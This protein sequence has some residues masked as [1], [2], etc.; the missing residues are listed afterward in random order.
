MFRFS[1][2]RPF[3]G[4]IMTSALALCGCARAQDAPAQN[5]AA[6]SNTIEVDFSQSPP[7]ERGLTFDRQTVQAGTLAIK[8]QDY[9]AWVARKNLEPKM[10]WT[11]SFRFKVTDP[12][13]QG[14]K[15]PVVDLEI[16]YFQEADN[17]IAVRADTARGSVKLG[18]GKGNSKNW[19]T[20][21]LRL[22]D[23]YFGARDYPAQKL[24]TAGYDLR[25]DGANSD[26]WIKSV[27]IT[28]YPTGEGADWSRLL[29]VENARAQT[30]GGIL[31]FTRG[32]KNTL[33]F[34]VRNGANVARPLRYA[35]QIS[36][37]DGKTRLQKTGNTEIAPQSTQ[38][39]DVDFDTRN[40]PLGPYNGTISFYL[41][42]KT[43]EP[44]LQ[45][46]FGLGVVSDTV[47]PKARAGEFLFG[48]DAANSE[49]METHD[50]TA[51]ACY[52][53][54]GVDILR[55][56]YSKSSQ[57]DLAGTGADLQLLAREG[58]QTAIMARP[59][60]A[61]DDA[62]KNAAEL[63]QVTANLEAMA[64]L[65]AGD[66]PGKLHFWELGNEP[67]LPFFYAGTMEQYAAAMGAMYDAIKRG[68]GE[69][70]TMVM[71]GG[72]SFAGQTGDARSREFVQIVDP[73][74]LDI[75]AYHGHGPGIG[76][77]R[78]ALERVRQVA[79][80]HN[81][82]D[83]GFIETE[84]GYAAKNRAGLEEQA[85]TAVEK[86]TYAQSQGLPTFF[87]FRLF[88]EGKG[89]YGLTDNRVEPRPSVLA[90]RNLVERLRHHVF[91]QALPFA[92]EA[93]APGVS[94]FLF[95]ERDANGRATGRK[96]L[97]AF[98]E[99]A[100]SYDLSLRL[101]EAKTRIGEAQTFDL[102]GNAA[103]AKILPGNVAQLSVGA[104]PIYL[105]WSSTNAASSVQIAPSFLSVQSQEPLL[106]GQ[107]TPLTLLA[108]NPTNAPLQAELTI[109]ATSRLPIQ[110]TPAKRAINLAPGASQAIEL[111]AILGQTTAPLALPRWWKVF[112]N[113]DIGQLTGANYAAIPDAL[114]GAKSGQWVWAPDNRIN[115]GDLAGTFGEK[116]PAVAY[117]AID[118]AKAVTLPVAASAD[119]WM[120]WYLNGHK[121]YDTLE[122]GDK[123]SLADQP[124]DLPLRQGRNVLAVLVLSGSGGW[125]IEW[126]GPRER[127]LALTNSAPD[128]LTAT[129]TA[130]GV[131]L[132]QQEVPLELAAPIAPIEKA[133]DSYAGWQPLEPLAVLG[134]E[135]VTNFWVQEPDQ[136]RW[137]GG[138]K[139]LSAQV[140]LRDDGANLQL[141][142]AARDDKL[143]EAQSVADLSKS[144][145][146]RLVLSGPNGTLAEVRAGL[147]AGRAQITG[148]TAGIAAQVTRDENAP[149][150]AAT[151]YRLTIPKA[152]AGQTPFRLSLTLGDNDS[153]FLKQE[154]RLGEADKPNQGLRL[155]AP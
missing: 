27:K 3:L 35:V 89:A 81:K 25:I 131:T 107:T 147:V 43:T 26:L 95:E 68:A 143:V 116:R 102:Y 48:L 136:S 7:L 9:R 8:G 132:A 28:G 148:K 79:V 61:G 82:A 127:G 139:D 1:P 105:S 109:A 94:A 30:P 112:L 40:W 73:K 10:N 113:P 29:Q 138:D 76:A 74:K 71:N 23:A 58:L 114:P 83:L 66:G 124:F 51:L 15:M 4:V 47:L 142:V 31:A 96:T 125:D 62:A 123:G 149:G 24:S 140:W 67:D 13:F 14:G 72:L 37:Y 78:N 135:E 5:N 115:F 110:I 84:S 133:T 153:D 45:E 56:V 36:G 60:R 126:G 80:K 22:D 20:L 52:R 18:Y 93:G 122:S 21:K 2:F 69:K 77:E 108:R 16:T 46:S 59:P 70:P 106:T 88:M 90:Y 154:A 6:A 129:L 55:N 99:K 152:L 119:H 117:A 146:L 134:G 64:R 44:V 49:I 87:F 121:V 150:G 101:A 34:D 41:D 86:M 91:V 39:L 57:R 104:D 141:F 33:D 155:V 100:A 145:A 130:N 63:K 98:S 151:L 32:I 38:P 42:D 11:R 103:P 17:N 50:A 92:R 120:A 144:D 85:R 54:M 137:Y 53:L 19:K 75:I 118:A 12:R 111:N 97:V 128:K 65:Y